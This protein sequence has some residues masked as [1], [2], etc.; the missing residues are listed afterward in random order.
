MKM[1]WTD[2]EKFEMKLSIRAKRHGLQYFY[3]CILND[4][5]HCRQPSDIFW[6]KSSQKRQSTPTMKNFFFWIDPIWIPY[7]GI[8]FWKPCT[9][10][11]LKWDTY[12]T[13]FCDV[14]DSK[15]P[16]DRFN[17][18]FKFFRGW[19]NE[20]KFFPGWKSCGLWYRHVSKADAERTF[21]FIF[22]VWLL[23]QFK[24]NVFFFSLLDV[25]K[26]RICIICCRNNI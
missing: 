1:N 11:M 25:K 8:F 7:H 24:L 21:H 3:D 18:N 4:D 14:C 13:Y 19:N 17:S 16:N 22:N 15:P 26:I 2:K 5:S 6:Q 9:P 20:K 23:L 12:F 10:S